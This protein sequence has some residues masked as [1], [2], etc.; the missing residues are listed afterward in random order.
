MGLAWEEV[1]PDLSKKED[2]KLGNG[3]GPYTNEA[4]GAENYG[5][6]SYVVESPQDKGVFWVATDDGHVQ[7]TKD[8]CKTWNNVTPKGLPECLV[9]AIDISPHDPAVAYIACTRYKFNDHS[10][11]LYRTADYGKTWVNISKGIP[12]GAYTR[13][14]REDTER[15]GMLFAGTETGV[16]ISWD[17]GAKWQPLQLN[18]PV[19]PVNDLMIAHDDVIVATSGRSFWILDDLALFR[20]YDPK[21]KNL[22]LYKPEPTILSNDYSP[23]NS[24]SKS[25]KG[26]NALEGV[27]PASG[28]VLYYHL[29]KVDKDKPVTL[30][31]KDSKGNVIRSLTSEKDEDYQSWAG[32]PPSEPEVSKE[33]G[34]N[35]FVWDLRYP[36]MDGVPDVYIEASFRG[37]KVPP[38]TYMVTIKHGDQ[39]STSAFEIKPNPLYSTTAAQYA[40]YDAFMSNLEKELTSMH[41]MVNNLNSAS[42]QIKE[43]LK[44][45]S[46]EKSNELVQKQGEALLKSIQSWDEDMVQRKSKAYDDVENFPNKFTANY[47]FLI[48][49]TE[50]SLPRVNQSSHDRLAELNQEWA[51]LKKQG[52][53]LLE[54]E[55]P[56]F[57]KMLWDA[58]IGAIYVK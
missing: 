15:K 54:Q 47:M 24:T 23:L 25:F 19:T 21:N 42:M 39:E 50:S 31:I 53:K 38:G 57:S 30:V 16:Y 33:E 45:M 4:V 18:L 44:K 8:N 40:E 52:E 34:L 2:E 46:K 17:N 49:Q 43:V 41:A 51:P 58:G 11:I 48:N 5:T 9:N 14:V 6:I 36:N 7:L 12:N 29:P 32:G 27:N 20:Q 37:H 35:R 55:V 3:G 13:V 22:K 1:S 56:A 28:A 10:P 26:S